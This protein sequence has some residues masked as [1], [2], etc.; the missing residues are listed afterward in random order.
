MQ[1]FIITAEMQ[2]FITIAGMQD[3]I[4]TEDEA[5]RVIE[6]GMFLQNLP[7]TFRS[8]KKVVISAVT[9][10]G[11]ALNH[12]AENLQDDKEVVFAAV[13]N[14]GG[15]LE[16]ASQRLRADKE[17]VISAVTNNGYALN[18]AAENFRDNKEV[19]FAAVTSIGFALCYAS[20]RLRADKE[21]VLSA[22]TRNGQA[23]KYA[24]KELRGDREVALAAAR[25]NCDA[26]HQISDELLQD[27]E[28]M[29]EALSYNPKKF[30][31]LYDKSDRN[32][33]KETIYDLVYNFITQDE[34][35]ILQYCSNQFFADHDLE[36]L[37]AC[38]DVILH[39]PE[40]YI[41]KEAIAKVI[42]N[43]KFAKLS[44]YKE[45]A[46]ELE[47]VISTLQEIRAAEKIAPS[48]AIDLEP[49]AKEMPLDDAHSDKIEFSGEN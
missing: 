40:Q 14:N 33:L 24:S 7:Q 37:V 25:D 48:A 2:N 9:N 1:N 20:Q 47:T 42:R 10:D 49:S 19:V 22:V 36:L 18:R 11:Y 17:V 35:D 38:N 6:Q 15:A 41:T 31:A 32:L 44:Q 12:A 4:T 13:T 43:P 3:F 30:L 46:F 16:F 28:F 29:Q 26:L 27:H 39:L 23:L 8:N 34:F 21:V 5:I 45:D